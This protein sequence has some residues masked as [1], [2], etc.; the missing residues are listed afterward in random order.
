MIYH[1][2]NI[3]NIF[4]M[5]KSIFRPGNESKDADIATKLLQ[6]LSDS[7]SVDE[8]REASSDLRDA[9]LN[10]QKSKS[11]VSSFGLE[12]IA[13]VVQNNWGEEDVVRNCL[14]V[15]AIIVDSSYSKVRSHSL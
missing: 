6:T 3:Y 5:F 7:Y 4:I 2:Y 1:F 15:L 14:E 12:V 9:L 13:N 11:T 8:R 10:D